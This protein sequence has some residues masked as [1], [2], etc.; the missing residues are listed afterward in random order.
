MVPPPKP[1]DERARLAALRG[2]GLLDSVAED[3]FDRITRL[4]RRVL[5]VP[6]ALVS[7]VDADR[8]WFK[9]RQGLDACQTSR[10]V[11]FCGHAILDDEPLVIPDARRDVRF[12]DNPLVTADPDIRFY[13]GCPIKANG[14]KVGTLCVIDRVPRS[15]GAEDLD[16]L[17]DLAH[18][19]EENLTALDL[20]TTDELTG[21]SNQRGFGLLA[22]NA[23]KACRRAGQQ[24]TVAV[25]D[26][27]GFKPINDRWGHAEGDRALKTFSLSLLRVFRDSD[28]VGR[29][30]G[31]EF[32]VFL[33][34][35][36][37]GQLPVC[38]DRL[39]DH[40]TEACVREAR[41]YRIEY[42]I[43][44]FGCR[45]DAGTT[46]ARMLA[47]ADAAMYE[48]KAARGGLAVRDPDTT[49]DRLLERR[50]G[51]VAAIAASIWGYD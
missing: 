32:G 29:L 36:R 1:A 43:G 21:L 13:A 40:L 5:R 18:M 14:H 6:I 17:R 44:S 11:S 19:V 46:V 45:P 39:N 31:D 51:D 24:A 16:L 25:F 49:V 8:Q 12:R 41:P 37:D 38:I 20:A 9:S 28:V 35:T 22:D 50:G 3:R 2:L 23:L 27:D 30:G 15:P 10:E 33:S 4:A 47:R 48:H 34:G 42:S 26:L 7:L